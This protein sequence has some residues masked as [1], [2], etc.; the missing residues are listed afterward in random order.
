MVLYITFK[1]KIQLNFINWDPLNLLSTLSYRCGQAPLIG[2]D[3]IVFGFNFR[4]LIYAKGQDHMHLRPHIYTN[5]L[6]MGGMVDEG[7]WRGVSDNDS[8]YSGHEQP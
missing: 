3:P 5:R 6:K 7:E 8:H 1:H 2:H 4:C